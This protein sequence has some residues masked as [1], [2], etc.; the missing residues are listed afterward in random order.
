MI[1]PGL[2]INLHQAKVKD[3][4]NCYVIANM[5]Y[6]AGVARCEHCKIISPTVLQ[7]PAPLQVI[8]DSLTPVALALTA[9]IGTY[10]RLSEYATPKN[11]YT[12]QS[13]AI[14]L[15]SRAYPPVT[16]TLKSS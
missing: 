9:M 2:E 16:A 1:D 15:T 4:Y 7:P 5:T 12:N 10:F 3:Y 11:T 6:Q 13:F 8:P 14:E